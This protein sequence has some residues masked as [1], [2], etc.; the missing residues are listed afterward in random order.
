MWIEK[1]A[2]LSRDSNRHTAVTLQDFLVKIKE[3]FLSL[4]SAKHHCPFYFIYD[5]YVFIHVLYN[6]SYTYLDCVPL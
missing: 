3:R 1:N 6:L 5:I 2:V 4:D